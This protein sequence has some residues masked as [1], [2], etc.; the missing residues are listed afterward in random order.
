[1]VWH[2]KYLIE[3]KAIWHVTVDLLNNL[4]L[5]PFGSN[6]PFKTVLKKPNNWNRPQVP[7]WDEKLLLSG[8]C[9]FDFTLFLICKRNWTNVW[10]GCWTL[11][12]LL[13][14]W[15][16][17]VALWFKHLKSVRYFGRHSIWNSYISLLDIKCTVH[18]T[19]T[20]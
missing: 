12:C 16:V 19:T 17:I 6:S 7:K 2:P 13:V 8:G 10:K 3:R 11:Q 9:Y 18:T 14:K 15:L 5:W 1:M 4:S 20:A